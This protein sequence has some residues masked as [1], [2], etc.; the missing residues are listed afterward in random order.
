MNISQEEDVGTAQPSASLRRAEMLSE[1]VTVYLGDCRNILPTLSGIDVSIYSPPYNLGVSRWAMGRRQKGHHLHRQGGVGYDD[2][3]P[4]AEY[5][6][7]QIEALEALHGAS[8]EGASVFYNHKP[9]TKGGQ[10]T[11][12]Y[13]WLSASP[14]RVRQEIVWDRG[15]T[16]NQERTLF[17]QI[18]ERLWWLTKGRPALAG[19]VGRS[20]VWRLHGPVRSEHPAPFREELPTEC[21]LAI[22][23]PD[24]LVC[25]P[26]MGSGTTGVAAVKLGHRFIGI[27]IHEP[28]FDLACRRISAALSQ[29]ANAPVLQDSTLLEK[30]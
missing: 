17:R 15:S 4:R 14:W 19:D 2:S 20:T 30:E 16:H 6:A 8:K 3:L 9:R 13:S 29:G 26:F 12:P 1:R 21:L 18:D 24:L 10:M 28:F 23:L 25:D 22:G 5:A 27:E 11:H 7:Q